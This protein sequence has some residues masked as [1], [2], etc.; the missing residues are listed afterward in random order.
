MDVLTVEWLDVLRYQCLVESFERLSLY[1]F[2]A[3]I[4]LP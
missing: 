3:L 2:V 4:I 1:V